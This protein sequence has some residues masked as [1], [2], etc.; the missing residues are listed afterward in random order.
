MYLIY[1]DDDKMHIKE[2][3]DET[4][5]IKG[6]GYLISKENLQKVNQNIIDSA[7]INPTYKEINMLREYYLRRYANKIIRR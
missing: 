7:L 5:I 2:G 3:G 1:F 4:D 6:K